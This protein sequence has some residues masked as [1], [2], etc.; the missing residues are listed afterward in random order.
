MFD[1]EIHLILAVA[2]LLLLSGG[3]YAGVFMLSRAG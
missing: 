3:L 2:G 1:D